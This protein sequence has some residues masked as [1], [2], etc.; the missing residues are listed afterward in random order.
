MK[1]PDQTI[2]VPRMQCD[3]FDHVTRQTLESARIDPAG[4]SLPVIAAAL[5]RPLSNASGN[6]VGRQAARCLLSACCVLS[7][8]PARVPRWDRTFDAIQGDQAVR[9]I[10]AGG[11]QINEAQGDPGAAVAYFVDMIPLPGRAAL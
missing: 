2:T 8:P 6:Y 1:S 9:Q 7:F 5:I 3:V 10:A 11:R 4:L